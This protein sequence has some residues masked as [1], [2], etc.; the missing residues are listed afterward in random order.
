MLVPEDSFLDEFCEPAV[1]GLV[2]HSVDFDP[3]ED[4]QRL[5]FEW[6]VDVS[7]PQMMEDID[8]QIDF[9]HHRSGDHTQDFLCVKS[10]FFD[11]CCRFPMSLLVNLPLMPP[12]R[13]LSHMNV[14]TGEKLRQSFFAVKNL[15]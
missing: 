12:F 9:T 3:Q 1:D 13:V 8:V 15:L 6:S 7:V 2:F 14:C 5:D 11:S 10:C 4:V